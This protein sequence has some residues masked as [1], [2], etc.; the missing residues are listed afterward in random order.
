MPHLLTIL[1]SLYY[2][3]T[4]N[5]HTL[6]LMQVQMDY[7]SKNILQILYMFIIY[8]SLLLEMGK[9]M[10]CYLLWSY[11]YFHNWKERKRK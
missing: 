2:T 1:P 7:L 4:P 9:N 10:V 5:I 6:D 3:H 11:S 8:C